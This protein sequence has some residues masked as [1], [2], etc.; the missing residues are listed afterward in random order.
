MWLVRGSLGRCREEATNSTPIT[1]AFPYD[2]RP[3]WPEA[4]LGARKEIHVVNINYVSTLLDSISLRV[5]SRLLRSQA[6][7]E[8]MAMRITFLALFG[9]KAAK[10]AMFSMFRASENVIRQPYR[11]IFTS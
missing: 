5:L 1:F 10:N 9:G 6:V 8:C 2:V 3:V 11:A 7:L 4:L